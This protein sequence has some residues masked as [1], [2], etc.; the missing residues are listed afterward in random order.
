MI[1]AFFE[2]D[3][4]QES[5]SEVATP[6]FRTADTKI[7]YYSNLL[8]LRRMSF[9]I[10]ARQGEPGQITPDYILNDSVESNPLALIYKC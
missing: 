9:S 2:S 1:P 5:G 6:L 10:T 3:E 7:T 4:E 8:E